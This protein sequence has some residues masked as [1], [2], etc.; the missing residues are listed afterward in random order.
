MRLTVSQE[1]LPLHAPVF[2][3]LMARYSI[4]NVL[5]LWCMMFNKMNPPTRCHQVALSHTVPTNSPRPS[6]LNWYSCLPTPPH[7]RSLR[8]LLSSQQPAPPKWVIDNRGLTQLSLDLGC[9]VDSNTPVIQLDKQSWPATAVILA[10]H[11][12]VP[13]C[14]CMQTHSGN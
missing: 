4:R 13:R 6:H 3:L 5:A 11:R 2:V 14:N 8:S 1:L 10:H 9:A 12:H 7:Y